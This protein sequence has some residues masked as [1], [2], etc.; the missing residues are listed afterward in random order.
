M[1]QK[2]RKRDEIGLKIVFLD[3]KYLFFGTPPPHLQKNCLNLFCGIL[4]SPP[5]LLQKNPP[6]NIWK[7]PL[8]HLS[9]SVISLRS[10]ICFS[11]FKRSS[12]TDN[13]VWQL[14]L[15]WCMSIVHWPWCNEYVSSWRKLL[16]YL[17]NHSKIF[18]KFGFCAIEWDWAVQA[19][20]VLAV[21]RINYEG[22]HSSP[23]AAK[24]NF[25]FSTLDLF[26]NKPLPVCLRPRVPLSISLRALH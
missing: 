21:G 17:Q 11:N 15:T 26:S 22:T 9:V 20:R 1:D 10:V 5:P 16:N 23:I 18:V 25:F 24:F 19:R 13:K 2:G 3:Q 12:R 14:D 7:H 4:G 8:G 6:N